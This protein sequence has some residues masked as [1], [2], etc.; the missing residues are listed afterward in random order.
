MMSQLTKQ[1]ENDNTFLGET[2]GSTVLDSGAS[3]EQNGT[4][5]FL[6]H[7]LT[8]KEKNNC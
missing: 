4:I 8:Y 6:K 3:A 7:L 1:E 2:L 5:V